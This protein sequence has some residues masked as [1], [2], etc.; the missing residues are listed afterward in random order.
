MFPALAIGY[1]FET[2]SLAIGFRFDAG[3]L[4]IGYKF[5]T[6]S[7]AISYRFDTCLHVIHICIHTYF[8]GPN[9]AFQSKDLAS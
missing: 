9:R 1:M 2:S 8:I 6:G 4:A 3:S 7:L 5:D